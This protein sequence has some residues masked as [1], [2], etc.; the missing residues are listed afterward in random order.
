M[1]MK[2]DFFDYLATARQAA[3]QAGAILRSK[4]GLSSLQVDKKGRINLVTEAD[5]A[6]EES[7][8]Q[9]ILSQ[10]PDHE[11]LGEES[12][13]SAHSGQPRWIVDPLDGTTNFAQGYPFFSISIALE[14]ERE[15]VAGVVY[16]PTHNEMFSAVKQQG[17]FLND[18]P[19]RVSDH[20]ILEEALLVTGFPYELRR[21]PD[22]LL[23]LFRELIVR[24]RGIRRDGSAALDL[25]YTACGR[26]DAFWEVGLHPWDIAAGSLIVQEAGGRITN[27][28][29]QPHNLLYP[30]MLASNSLLHA[31]ILKAIAPHLDQLH[32][33]ALLAQP[34]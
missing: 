24:A 16:D 25:C 30:E 6:S 31:P 1:P 20:S 10:Y 23:Q 34:L 33:S 22:I 17:A 12:G 2:N 18:Q 32:S 15:I 26:F 13:L 7:I 4:F 21:D 29:D 19:I 27:F 5:V 9:T 14:I 8:R 28:S 11:F 3:L